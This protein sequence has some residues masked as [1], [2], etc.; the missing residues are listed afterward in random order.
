M[1]ASVQPLQDERTLPQTLPAEVCSGSL[2]DGRDSTHFLESPNSSNDQGAGQPFT[3]LVI[4]T[5]QAPEE[6]SGVFP[7]LVWEKGVV[8]PVPY[9]AEMPE[10]SPLSPARNS[11]SLYSQPLHGGF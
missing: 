8:Q 3:S 11:G 7:G 1:T 2:L 6:C 10:N 5:V 9:F 4:A